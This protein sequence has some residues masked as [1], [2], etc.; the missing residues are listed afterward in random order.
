[1]LATNRIAVA[2]VVIRTTEHLA[3]VVVKGKALM[4]N[5]LRY[6]DELRD[7]TAI[8]IPAAGLKAGVSRRRRWIS[9]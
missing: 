4:L 7:A 2:Q 1:M 9:P 8:D 3:A 5:T 6:Q